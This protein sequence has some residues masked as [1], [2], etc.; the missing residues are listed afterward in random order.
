M[1]VPIA[2]LMLSTAALAQP[3]YDLLLKGGH[4][5]DGKNRISAVRD[6]AIA[7]AKSPPSR[8]TSPPPKP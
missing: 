4:V 3:E 5:I 6:V 2:M 8:R 7:T 1:N